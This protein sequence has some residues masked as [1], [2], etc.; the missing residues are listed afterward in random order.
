MGKLALLRH[1][2]FIN[3]FVDTCVYQIEILIDWWYKTL[4]P[5]T[6]TRRN[7]MHSDNDMFIMCEPDVTAVHMYIIYILGMIN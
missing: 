3:P 2:G 6:E 4:A 1:C 7:V 5:T